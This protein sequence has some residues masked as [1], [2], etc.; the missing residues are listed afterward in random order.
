MKKILYILIGV[1]VVAGI[2]W[3]IMT[4]GKPGKLDTFAKCIKESGAVFYGAFWCPHCQAQKAMFGKS[5][6]YLPYV[7][8]STADGKDQ[9]PIC[10]EKKVTTYPTWD[11]PSKNSSV[12]ERMTGEISLADLSAKTSCVLQE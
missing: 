4:P 2:V 1:L 12:P 5:A 10:K 9:F 7:E 6:Q 11:F 8:C 3:L